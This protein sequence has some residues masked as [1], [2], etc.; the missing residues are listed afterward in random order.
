VVP[1]GSRPRRVRQNGRRV[2]LPSERWREMRRVTATA[3]APASE[4]GGPQ[5]PRE[6]PSPSEQPSV[7]A[8]QQTAQTPARHGRLGRLFERGR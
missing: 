4:S 1:R 6:Q 8:E 5:D 3:E 2:I 7:G